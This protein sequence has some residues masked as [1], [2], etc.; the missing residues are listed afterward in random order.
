MKLCVPFAVVGVNV[1][2]GL[3]VGALLVRMGIFGVTGLIVLGEGVMVEGAE[4]PFCWEDRRRC[5]ARGAFSFSSG[6]ARFW[7]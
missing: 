3:P 4:P 2:G 6:A 7:P 5:C 1:V